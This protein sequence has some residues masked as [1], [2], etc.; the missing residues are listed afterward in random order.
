MSKVVEL[1]ELLESVRKNGQLGYIK[2]IK[3]KNQPSVNQLDLATTLFKKK[4]ANKVAGDEILNFDNKE[5]NITELENILKRYIGNEVDIYAGGVLFKGKLNNSHNDFKDLKKHFN[6]KN[7]DIAE[8]VGL[9]TDS[10]KTMTQPNKELPSW[11]KSMMYVWK[12]QKE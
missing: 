11:V 7:S 4:Y 3:P 2:I 6:L 12:K 5:L 9:T 1:S 8:I 10:V